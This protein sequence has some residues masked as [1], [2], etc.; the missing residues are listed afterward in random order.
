[1]SDAITIDSST[2]NKLLLWCVSFGRISAKPVKVIDLGNGEIKVVGS[3]R[4]RQKR[5][6]RNESYHDTYKAAL[7]R[8]LAN[9]Q[10]DVD[11]AKKE[12][13]NAQRRL[14]SVRAK[15]TSYCAS[16]DDGTQLKS[17]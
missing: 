13:S 4:I 7:I 11:D 9:A 3:C 17:G 6:E 2:A 10:H 16:P 15:W 5:D 1:M 8:L 12:L 14:K